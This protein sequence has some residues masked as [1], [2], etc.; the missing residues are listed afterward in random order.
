[1]LG[2]VA[3]IYLSSVLDDI[4]QEKELHI[5]ISCLCD[6]IFQ[7]HKDGSCL[8]F[9]CVWRSCAKKSC[10]LLILS[11]RRSVLEKVVVNFLVLCGV[12]V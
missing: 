3:A 10:G 6:F 7:G 4:L 5:H 2:N 8:Q 12:F 11:V 9:L 1:M